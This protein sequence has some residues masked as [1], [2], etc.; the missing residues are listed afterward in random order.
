[1]GN[2]SVAIRV[3]GGDAIA[4]VKGANAL[5]SLGNELFRRYACKLQLPR[6]RINNQRPK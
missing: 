1:M 3:L 6:M 2:V 4:P 5:R